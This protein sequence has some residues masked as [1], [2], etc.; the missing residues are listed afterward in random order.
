MSN[1]ENNNVLFCTGIYKDGYGMIPKAVMKNKKISFE[2]KAVYAYICSY[3]G[4]GGKAFPS[5]QKICEELGISEKRLY[6]YRKEL[7]DNGLIIISKERLGSKYSSN[8]YTIVND[9][10]LELSESD[11]K[12]NNQNEPS[13]IG[14]VQNGN[15]QNGHVQYEPCRN[16][17]TI[18]NILTSN[19]KKE[20]KK[21]KSTNLDKLILAYTE[22]KN[23]QQTLIDFIKMRKTIKKPVTDRA[24]KAIFKR[25]DI[26][27]K[28]DNEKIAILEKSIM[29][30]YQG[31]FPLTKEDFVPA[32]KPK[33]ESNLNNK[34]KF[35]LKE[36][37]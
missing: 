22:N 20:N 11:S 2:A 9:P 26:F 33:V 8:I 37:M 27:A 35:I 13:Q 5:L 6:K 1:I 34:P 19:N 4:S 16:V 31:V 3:A 36:D 23:L 30:C 14:H 24:L 10:K 17:G 25:L 15:V 18:S 29:N 12:E 32:S 21:E 7:V 28:N